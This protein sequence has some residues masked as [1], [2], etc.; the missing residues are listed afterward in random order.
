MSES[1][2]KNVDVVHGTAEAC[3]RQPD[4]DSRWQPFFLK[5]LVEG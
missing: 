2:S 1:E 5:N 4:L 3:V